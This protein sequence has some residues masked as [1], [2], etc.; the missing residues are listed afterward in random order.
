[1]KADALKFEQTLVQEVAGVREF[2]QLTKPTIALLVVVTT[3]PTLLMTDIGLPP[4]ITVVAALIGT[5]LAASSAGSFNQI[6]DMRIDA[7]MN[8][9]KSRPLVMGKL[10]QQQALF[11]AT[12]L[13]IVSFLIL[14]IFTTMAAAVIALI[15][16]AFYVLFYTRYLKYKTTQN[17]VIG[18]AAGAVGPLIG[19][20]A[21]TG[22]VGW[23]AWVLF[24]IIFLWTPPHFW[25]LAIKYKDDYEL[26]HI[27]MLP[28]V[29][30]IPETK[31][32]IFAY[33]L[34]L[35]PCVLSLYWGG[36]AGMMYLA[37]AFPL[38]VYFAWISWQLL[39]GRRTPMSV[40]HYSCMYVFGVFGA[41]VLDRMLFLG[42]M[43]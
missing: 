6:M 38:T 32:Q 10:S 20:A 26:A 17:I 42:G 13:G 12:V 41:L 4:L 21:I 43:S 2:F 27:P 35:V 29:K 39:R 23:P 22:T 25:S 15:A 16:N 36:A 34:T 8:R 11:F 18:G 37:F 40:F 28:V 5:W 9:T 24:L 33:T 19:W 30:G 14:A 1:M 3:I 31:R 7:T